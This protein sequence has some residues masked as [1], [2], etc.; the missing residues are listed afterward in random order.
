MQ[1]VDIDGESF[2]VE[3][4]GAGPPLMLLHGFPLDHTMWRQ[5]LEFF[6]DR[7]RVGAPDLRGFG[8]SVVTPARVPRDQMADDCS[9]LLDARGIAEPVTLCGLS[10]G[11]YVA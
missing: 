1:Q 6:S 5:Q 10:M 4:R 11:G 9:R 8:A 7:W 2:N 3:V